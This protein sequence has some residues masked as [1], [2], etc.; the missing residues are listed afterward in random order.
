VKVTK[1]DLKIVLN[2]AYRLE[3]QL[4]AEGYD[5]SYFYTE[6]VQRAHERMLVALRTSPR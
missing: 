1:K 2:W 5:V 6:P 3:K 4:A